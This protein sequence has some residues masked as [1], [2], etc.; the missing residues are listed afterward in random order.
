MTALAAIEHNDF[1]RLPGGVF[2]RAYVRAFAAEVGLKKA[3]GSG[4]KVARSGKKQEFIAALLKV[5]GVAYQGT[6]PA[7][8]CYPRQPILAVSNDPATARSMNIL[9]GTEGVHVDIPFSRTSTDHIAG[10]LG[11]LWRRGKLVDEDLVLVTSVAYPRSGNRMNVI[12]MHRV[13]DLSESQGWV[14]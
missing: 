4:F 7:V 11:E 12:Q 14:R 2:R 8:M 3:M 5:P 10:C 9:F 6:V 1:A 13:A